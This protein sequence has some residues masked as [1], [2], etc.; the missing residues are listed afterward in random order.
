MKIYYT[1][2]FLL[3]SVVG[4]SQSVNDYAYVIVPEK[5]DFLKSADQHQLNSLTKFL[6][7]KYGFEA[8][9]EEDEKPFNVRERACDALYVD[10]EEESNFISTRLAILLEDCDGKVV[11][12]AIQ[13][14]SKKKDFKQAYHEALR[15]AFVEIEQLNYTFQG[16]SVKE[17]HKEAVQETTQVTEEVNEFIEPTQEDLDPP[18]EMPLA[19]VTEKPVASSTI[20]DLPI[21]EQE[22]NEE[23]KLSAPILF[24]S[25]DNIYRA[26]RFSDSI[27][28][29]EGDK[30]IGR[31]VIEEKGPFSVKTSQ[32]EGV[33]NFKRGKLIIER[34]IKGIAGLIEMI[35]IEQ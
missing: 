34:K 28:F 9:M 33:G 18:S 12:K 25:E 22:L 5:Y 17:A 27:I 31:A 14:K 1:L 6:F 21:R 19:T 13:G 4:F 7:N 29:Y 15:N 32:F 11:Y 26:L 10:L 30:N 35:F 2:C 8:Y 16:K 24:L 23:L 3:I 20:K